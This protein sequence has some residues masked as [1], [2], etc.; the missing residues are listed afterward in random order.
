MQ[1]GPG[2]RT[3][4]FL[5]GCPLHCPWCCNPENIRFDKQFYFIEEICTVNRGTS[6]LCDHC[7]AA[8]VLTMSYPG[9][10]PCC[11]FGAIG[12]YGKEYDAQEL[13]RILLK[14]RLYWE[15]GGVTFS[16]GEALMQ[17]RELLPAM[18]LLKEK[19]IHIAVET[20]LCVPTELLETV[21]D[22]VDLFL[23]DVKILDKERSK[24][25]LDGDVDLL[26]KNVR[27]A[28]ADGKEIVFRIPCC[29]DYTLTDENIGL[30]GNFFADYP[31][32]PV[33]LFRLHTLGISKHK[34]LGCLPVSE[35]PAC[36][37]RMKHLVSIIEKNSNRVSIITF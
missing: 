19:D 24:D 11:P 7:P 16:G 2:I 28:A 3:T 14:D 23:I 29:D 35:Y 37:N 32:Y 30:L 26:Y 20:S 9:Q 34:S 8:D 12:V 1:D 17:A 22:Y 5:K 15:G 25:I 33:E 18:R 6:N 10:S 4:V 21:I 13:V 36:E 31:G 27:R